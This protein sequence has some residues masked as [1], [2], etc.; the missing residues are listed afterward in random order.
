[1]DSPAIP[2]ESLK[3]EKKIFGTQEHALILFSELMFYY[4]KFLKIT[5]KNIF[6]LLH[7]KIKNLHFLL[8]FLLQAYFKVSD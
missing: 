3:K 1:M 5:K 6:H 2:L 4:Y 8:L 7:W